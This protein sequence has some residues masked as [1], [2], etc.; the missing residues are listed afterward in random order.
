V[1]TELANWNRWARF[2]LH[3]LRHF[4][5]AYAPSAKA[6]DR[7]PSVDRPLDLLGERIGR[8]LVG[9]HEDGDDATVMGND[10]CASEPADRMAIRVGRNV[11]DPQRTV[12]MMV[13]VPRRCMGTNSRKPRT[14]RWLKGADPGQPLYTLYNSRETS[15]G[16]LPKLI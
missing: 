4:A 8:S 13:F 9:A 16:Y 6:E 7:D 12:V 11:P 5:A 14:P 2:A 3:H 15:L 1:P 10:G